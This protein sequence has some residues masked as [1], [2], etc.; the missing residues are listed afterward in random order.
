M[1]MNGTGLISIGHH[2]MLVAASKPEGYINELPKEIGKEVCV[3]VCACV[4]VCVCI[5]VHVHVCVPHI[6]LRY[7][8]WWEYTRKFMNQT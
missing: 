7:A 8:W 6:C 3:C 5:C 2:L 4:C 1:W